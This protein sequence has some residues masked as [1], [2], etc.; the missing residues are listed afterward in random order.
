[1]QTEQQL[2]KQLE[3]QIFKIEKFILDLQQDSQWQRIF[4]KQKL[5]LNLNQV[6]NRPYTDYAKYFSEIMT[7]YKILKSSQN[8]E[9]K[10]YFIHKI[11][12]KIFALF[13]IL[14]S[15]NKYNKQQKQD[16]AYQ[17][18]IKQQQNIKLANQ[19]D[20]LEKMRQ[21][22]DKQYNTLSKQFV[23]GTSKEDLTNKL[24][25]LLE[26]K[27]KIERELFSITELIKLNSF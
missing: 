12:N 14:R 9:L 23:Y 10:E 13:K 18:S 6:F 17:V 2:L 4:Y 16:L 27:G 3:L 15:L 5:Y 26:K 21:L 19:R 8:E 11:E 22:L 1:M 20:S 24:I 7:D 25:L